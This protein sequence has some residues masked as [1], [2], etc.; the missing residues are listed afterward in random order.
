MPREPQFDHEA[1]FAL[2]YPCRNYSAVAREVG[3]TESAVRQVAEKDGWQVRAAALEADHRADIADGLR[4]SDQKLL[5]DLISLRATMPILI[6]RIISDP[7]R[8]PS[9]SAV[10]RA[11]DV[12]E[13]TIDRLR[14]DQPAE[15]TVSEVAERLGS[16]PA[17]VAMEFL[18][19]MIENPDVPDVEILE[20]AIR[21][22]ERNGSDGP[23]QGPPNDPAE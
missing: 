13:K 15:R 21:L 2:W 5:D 6:A 19:M 11:M 18:R 10:V 14:P 8:Q 4:A 12:L 23:Y 7:N 3:V 22:A 1:A 9:L 20:E 17:P 16:V